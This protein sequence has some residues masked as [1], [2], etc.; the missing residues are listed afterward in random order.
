M[1][2]RKE[3]IEIGKRFDATGELPV[4]VIKADAYTAMERSAE[5]AGLS[6]S[7][8]VDT[9]EGASLYRVYKHASGPEYNPSPQ[10]KKFAS[11]WEALRW[12]EREHIRKSGM[13][14]ARGS[15]DTVDPAVIAESDRALLNVAEGLRDASSGPLKGLPLR[16]IISHLKTS[17]AYGSLARSGKGYRAIIE[18]MLANHL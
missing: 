18:S 15:R 7:K 5:K 3:L 8:Y 4:S 16:A 13:T 9:A 14:D 2:K 1:S 6:F 17:P 12:A 11:S 10:P